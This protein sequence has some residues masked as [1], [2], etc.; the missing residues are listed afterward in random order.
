MT[1]LADR[2]RDVIHDH[3]L[4]PRN[5]GSI[6]DP[7][8]AAEGFNPPCGDR[9]KVY[10]LFQRD[11]IS[12]VRFEGVGCEIALAS[13]SLMTGALKGKKRD[14][15]RRLYEEIQQ[16]MKHTRRSSSSDSFDLGALES[17]RGLPT[18]AEKCAGLAWRTLSLAIDG[19]T[20]GES[21]GD[22]FGRH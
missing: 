3:F 11:V 21:V 12:E 2:Y 17:L 9:I 14:E 15:A 20:H 22:R 13:G 7:S 8:G 6:A 16:L 10:V 18:G 5:F 4:H 1:A 19:R